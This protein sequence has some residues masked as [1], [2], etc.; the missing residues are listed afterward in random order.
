MVAPRKA[1]AEKSDMNDLTDHRK[2]PDGEVRTALAKLLSSSDFANA[3][4]LQR[5]LTYV[6][7]QTLAGNRANI[8]GYTLGVDVFDRAADFDPA[9][10]AIVRVEAG[11]L[12]SK[13]RE[14]YGTAGSA[15]HLHIELPKGSYVPRFVNHNGNA[16]SGGPQ[17]VATRPSLLVQPFKNLSGVAEQDYFADGLSEDLIA[18][19]SRVRA[20]TLIARHSSFHY[21]HVAATATRIGSETGADYVLTG[22]VRHSADHIRVSAQLIATASEEV[23]WSSRYDRELKDVFALQDEVVE[24]IVGA[25]EIQLVP[26]T[27]SQRPVD[28][29]AYDLVSRGRECFWSYRRADVEEAQRLFARAIERAPDYALGHAWL[30]RALAVPVA[31]NWHHDRAQ[32]DAALR[33][34]QTAASLAPDLPLAHAMI[35]W[36][37]VWRG[38]VDDALL[39]GRHAVE[40][41]EGDFDA[42][43]WYAVALAAAGRGEEALRHTEIALRLDPHTPAMCI[44]ID[45]LCRWLLGDLPGAAIRFAR[46][47]N[48]TP[49]FVA[50]YLHRAACCAELEERA[51]A[52]EAIAELERRNPGADEDSGDWNIFTEMQAHDRLKHFLAL[53][54]LWFIQDRDT[55]AGGSDT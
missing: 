13:L 55:T 33:H 22:S 30:C 3:P 11:R 42:Q 28:L 24:S 5:F 40:L 17:P 10:D 9:I 8:K 41:D 23:L 52:V 20:L 35:A 44:F 53:A 6:V 36:T 4:R 2:A 50:F 26:S 46:G 51:A 49:D 25:L 7:E 43:L 14:Y 29:E 47:M 31:F 32:L 21:K 16:P 12:R 45:G 37:Q 34:A 19:L 39:A 18:A 1:R 38:A 48:R 54:R 15:E 27:T